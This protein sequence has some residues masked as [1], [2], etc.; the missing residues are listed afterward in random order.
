[1]LVGKQ[2]LIIE[3]SCQQSA[4]GIPPKT[5]GGA[6]GVKHSHY[7]HYPQRDSQCVLALLRSK[8]TESLQYTQNCGCGGI[9]MFR[10]FCCLEGAAAAEVMPLRCCCKQ[11]VSISAKNKSNSPQSAARSDSTP[12]A[13]RTERKAKYI[14]IKVHEIRVAWFHIFRLNARLE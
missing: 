11:L 6:K 10:K 2:K 4:L 1:M 5:K 3:A 12:Q 14:I 13:Q 7:S 9:K 8:L